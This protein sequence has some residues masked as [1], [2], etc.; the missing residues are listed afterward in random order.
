MAVRQHISGAPSQWQISTTRDLLTHPL[1]EKREE[2]FVRALCRT[3]SSESR[4]PTRFKPQL[5]PNSRSELEQADHESRLE[6]RALPNTNTPVILDI[7]Y[8]RT[9]E[10]NRHLTGPIWWAKT[11]AVMILTWR[12]E[13]FCSSSETCENLLDMY[14]KPCTAVCPTSV[15]GCMHTNA[16]IKGADLQ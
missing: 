12:F 4:Q 16:R 7:H 14:T 5:C 15:L 10:K 2:R 13:P 9:S 8:V 3:K 6:I 1:V 11:G